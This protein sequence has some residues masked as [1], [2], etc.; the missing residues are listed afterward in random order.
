MNVNEVEKFVKPIK[1][2]VEDSEIWRLQSDGLAIFLSDK[3]FETYN[4]PIHFE[5]FN[6][7][8]AG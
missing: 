2:L 8:R 4:F 3:I 5:E 7:L 6:Y 1:D